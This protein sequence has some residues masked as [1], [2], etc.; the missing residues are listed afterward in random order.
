MIC[1]L[2]Q[3]RK[4]R[5]VFSMGQLT[6]RYPHD[7]HVFVC[8]RWGSDDRITILANFSDT[9]SAIDDRDGV[10]VPGRVYRDLIGRQ[11]LQDSYMMHPWQFMLIEEYTREE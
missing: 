3:I 6:V 1:N 11:K 4:E 7:R 9:S 2:V 5:S 10:L 8:D